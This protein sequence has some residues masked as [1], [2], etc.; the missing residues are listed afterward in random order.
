MATAAARLLALAGFPVVVLER[1]APLAVRRLVCFAQAVFAGGC[2]VEGVEARR[3]GA[4][5]LGEGGFRPVP[6]VVD[7]EARLLDE[8]RPAVLV[9]GRMTKEPAVD[10]RLDRARLV[11][12][13]GPGFRAGEHAHA[14]VETERGPALG[15]VL[16]TGEAQPDT[17]RP[18]PVLGVSAGRVLRA[19][20]PGAFRGR[21]AL[22]DVVAEGDLVG[23]IGGRE[24]RAGVSGLLRGLLAD[25][26]EVDAGVKVGD[27]DPRG[28]E[29]DPRA[30]SATA[31]AVAAGVL[32]AVF[33]GRSRGA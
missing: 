17:G 8:V 3:V 19:P 4:E 14:V 16:R 6:V 31:R 13:L 21:R 10:R 26:V 25:G 28:R 5:R 30:V 12:G 7:P 9:D 18:S 22:G 24:V 33:L 27:V 11:V 15:R 1:P 20:V 29:V 23:E 32:E 2:V